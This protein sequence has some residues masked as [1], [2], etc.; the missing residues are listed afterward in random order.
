MLP[1]SWTRNM[2]RIDRIELRF[3]SFDL[4]K[5]FSGSIIYER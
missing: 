4:T 1:L 5:A 3:G 2:D